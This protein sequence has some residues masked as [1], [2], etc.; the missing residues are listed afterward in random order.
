MTSRPRKP[1]VARLGTIQ[2]LEYILILKQVLIFSIEALLMVGNMILSFSLELARLEI[3][4][5]L[6]FSGLF[7]ALRF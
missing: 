3:E 6:T 4:V 7:L 2:A 5:V 1:F